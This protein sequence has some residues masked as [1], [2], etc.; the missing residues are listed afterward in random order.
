MP[1]DL[2]SLFDPID[3]G[4]LHL[5]HRIAMAPMARYR[6]R[7]DGIPEDIVR[8][9]YEQRASA[10]LIVCESVYCHPTGRIAPLLG[11]LYTDAQ[12]TAWAAV[13]AAVHAQ[14]GRMFIQLMHGGRVSHPDVQPNGATPMA[15]SAIKARDQVRLLSGLVPSV[16][17]RPM[18]RADI[19]L[20]IESYGRAT[21]LARDA[22]F[23]GVELHAGNGYLPCQFVSSNTNRRTDAYGGSLANRCRFVLEALDAMSAVRGA[24]YVGVKVSPGFVYHDT[25]DANAE[26]TYGYLARQLSGLGLAYVH[27]QIPLDFIQ[28]NALSFDPVALVRTSYDGIV[29]AG[30]NFDRYSASARI[31]S[32]ACDVAIFGRRFIANPDLPER[33][34]RDAEENPW[35]AA[36][37]HTPGAA[38]YV[39]YP[40]L[41]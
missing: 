9:Y 27:V 31:A 2:S 41:S 4:S 7:E 38:G 39:D 29:L 26:E 37:L 22:G 5:P 23:D 28:P 6:C 1:T 14:G 19:H 35:D 40:R 25:H 17:P 12:V 8:F 11:G 36:T 30:G 15:P 32:G 3:V 16:T 33:I 10:A 21:R 34:R 24:E 20:V 13:A 18:T